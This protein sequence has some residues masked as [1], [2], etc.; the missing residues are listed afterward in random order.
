MNNQTPR[1][2]ELSRDI[3]ALESVIIEIADDETLTDEQRETELQRVF[4]RWLGAGDSF[5]AKAEQVAAYI[6]HQEALTEARRQE[7]RRLR[8][9]ADQSENQAKRLR[10]YLSKQMLA[11]G[12]TRI[13]GV[14]ATISLRKNPPRVLL[15]CD[16]SELPPDLVRVEY[17]PKLKAIKQLLEQN[18]DI[19]WAFLGTN[20]EYSV[21]IR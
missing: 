5:R 9:L 20:E 6:R 2:W 14:S 12:Q 4:A 19:E 15:N 8:T 10:G 18:P 16:P 13:D 17:H 3:E 11:A 7:Y 21:V 1:L